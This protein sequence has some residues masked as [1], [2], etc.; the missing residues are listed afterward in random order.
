[1][2]K[3]QSINLI[4]EKFSLLLGD[5]LAGVGAYFFHDAG[6][7]ADSKMAGQFPWGECQKIMTTDEEIPILFHHSCIFFYECNLKKKIKLEAC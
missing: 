5:S 3:L 7:Q 4:F 6:L 2:Q 1:M